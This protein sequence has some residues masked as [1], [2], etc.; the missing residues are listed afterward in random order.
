M[1]AMQIDGTSDRTIIL[2]HGWRGNSSSWAPVR[3]RLTDW[4]RVITVDL[5]G[6][7][8]SRDAPGPY[9][10]ARF[11]D[12]LAALTAQA[13]LDP[14]I[15]VGH[16]MGATAAVRFAIDQPEAVEALVL[17]APVPPG[18]LPLRERDDAFFRAS[19]EDPALMQRWLRMLTVKPVPE[20]TW[21]ELVGA[22]ALPSAE[23]LLE[24][25]ESWANADFAPEART[26]ETP[27]LC[28][29]GEGDRP[30]T[31]EVLRER[32]AGVIGPTE[33]VVIEDAGHYLQ[34]DKPELVAAEIKRFADSL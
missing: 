16:S 7:G 10:I 13:C 4:A 23:A 31:P 6:F 3:K 1:L 15:I 11:A 22:A 21:K 33:F 18:G 27:T 9:T 20:E 19:I 14:V 12:D 30:G 28:L 8:D 25:Y 32:I 5:R 26:I 17:V 29:A 34:I 2:V 24:S